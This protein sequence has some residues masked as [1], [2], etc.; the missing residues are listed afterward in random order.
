MSV[1]HLDAALRRL[2]QPEGA[3]PDELRADLDAVVH[4]L[5]S[6]HANG[7]R[8]AQASSFDILSE[9]V[10]VLILQ[11]FFHH[12]QAGS[13]QTD[14]DREM[15]VQLLSDWFSIK[16][17]ESPFAEENAANST[18]RMHPGRSGAEPVT[19]TFGDTEICLIM[20]DEVCSAA[21]ELVRSVTHDAVLTTDATSPPCELA[22]FVPLWLK[23]RSREARDLYID[24]AAGSGPDHPIARYFTSIETALATAGVRLLEG[25]T[26]M[27]II[28][29]GDGLRYHRDRL[30]NQYARLENAPETRGTYEVIQYLTLIDWD[31]QPECMSGTALDHPNGDR[32]LFA[33]WPG[34]V[35]GLF[36]SEPAQFPGPMMM[37][38]HCALP[39]FDRSAA[40]TTGTAKG[41]R[42][43]A[44][45]R[46]IAKT[47]QVRALREGAQRIAV[48]EVREE[49]EGV[50]RYANGV[51]VRTPESLPETALVP[52]AAPDRV[53]EGLSLVELD[54]EANR[55]LASHACVG[56]TGGV[57]LFRLEKHGE[58]FSD[59]ATAMR[60][61][62]G[63]DTEI[64]VINRSHRGGQSETCYPVAFDATQQGLPWIQL[65][66]A[67]PGTVFTVPPAAR[68]ALRMP[69]T[70]DILH[71]PALLDSFHS[72]SSA[73]PR[74]ALVVDVFVKP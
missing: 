63:P 41:K 28:A 9:N 67:Q 48:N 33:L 72:L 1:L 22:E 66:R 50:R 34:E 13:H 5:R 58:G 47:D 27:A 23:D 42:F 71:R 64:S 70:D 8:A 59:L 68:D 52:V 21:H 55:E 51:S 7:I 3:S 14:Y 20:S 16:I 69:P 40:R 61:F 73:R 29:N 43:S 60:E 19:L 25:S 17:D 32:Y 62:V 49:H 15:V 2:S 10:K 6:A 31:M 46:G 45:V 74:L 11:Q 44:L 18:T 12:S 24:N 4:H 35:V 65:C 30:V 37:P 56:D 53:S 36:F 26:E 39:V 38:Y 54:A 57:R